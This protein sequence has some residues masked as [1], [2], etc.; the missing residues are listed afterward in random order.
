MNS[1]TSLVAEQ[2][3]LKQWAGMIS[4]C[5]SRPAGMTVSEWCSQNGLTK[6]N[7]YYRL[8]RVREAF[9]DSYDDSQPSFVEL[10]VIPDR[11]GNDGLDGARAA[12]VIRH[13]NGLSV[14]LN[15]GISKDAL[16][17]IIE[18]FAYVQ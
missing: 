5:Q 18:V 9:I 3:R 7:Y 17:N 4:A 10:S 15:D 13:P 8:R 2:V 12:A 14:E 11:A 1:Q 16:K 6:A